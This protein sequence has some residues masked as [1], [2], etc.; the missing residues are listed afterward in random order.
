MKKIEDNFESIMFKSRWLLAWK[1]GIH[2]TFVVSG[3]L[4]VVTDGIFANGKSK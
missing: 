3:L 2:L 1:V 4:F